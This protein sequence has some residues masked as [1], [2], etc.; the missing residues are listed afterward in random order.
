MRELELKLEYNENWKIEYAKIKFFR[1]YEP[2]NLDTYIADETEANQLKKNKVHKLYKYCK[3]DENNWNNLI[4]YH[5][6]LTNPSKFNDPF[7]SVFS[8]SL[9]TN[10]ILDK[11][12]NV[13]GI[14]T[15]GSYDNIKQEI[16]NKYDVD[17]VISEVISEENDTLRNKTWVTC[18]SET[19]NSILMWSHYS[20]CH[21]GFCIEYDFSE[22]EESG[23]FNLLSPVLYVDKLYNIA[24]HPFNGKS[25]E[26]CSLL[27]SFEWHYE[28][29]WRLVICNL[30]NASQEFWRVPKPTAIYLGACIEKKNSELLMDFA[31]QNNIEVYPMKLSSKDYK[32][33][34]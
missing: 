33:I 28:K 32:L 34:V 2:F 3:F 10:E 5:V 9:N 20:D 27:K 1:K 17:K 22:E 13:L 8:I 25:F 21:K 11:V 29:E 12:I 31:K 16:K 6:H 26:F 4:N 14:S 19:N 15:S 18:F 7:D 24:E 30:E 23:L